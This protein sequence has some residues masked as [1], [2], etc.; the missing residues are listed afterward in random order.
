MDVGADELQG[1]YTWVDEIPLSRPKRNIAR[2]FSDGVLM[3]EV[4]HYYFPK[5][6]E[7][8][9]YS[10]ANGLQQKLYN[11]NTLNAKVFKRLGFMVTKQDS[12]A[13][14]HCK[15]GAVERVLKLIKVKIT[16]YKEENG[17]ASPG[18]APP[19]MTQAAE[20]EPMYGQQNHQGMQQQMALPRN[21]SMQPAPPMPMPMP[22]GV[23][24]PLAAK[25]NAAFVPEIIAEKD[26]VI[27]ELRETNQILETKVRKLEQLVR[28]KDAK[29]Q[30]LMAKLQ[31]AGMG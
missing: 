3:A 21:T 29:I 17:D 22:M 13:C 7:L 31:G 30:T 5:L 12:E 18:A 2:D 28:L 6:V 14:C 4:V 25:M 11:W 24:A 8:H 26:T 19:T 16:K 15:P 20:P 10:S 1:L 27:G 9:N 23:M